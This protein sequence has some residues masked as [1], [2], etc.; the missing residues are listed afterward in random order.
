MKERQ[1]TR[2]EIMSYYPLLIRLSD[3]GEQMVV[4]IPEKIPQGR[5][6]TVLETK[7]FEEKESRWPQCKKI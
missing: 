6:F 4:G 2:E 3:T 5:S 1:Y 7:Y